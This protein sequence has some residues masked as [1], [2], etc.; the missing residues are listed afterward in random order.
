LSHSAIF[1]GSHGYS[2]FNESYVN[3]G[4]LLAE[5]CWASVSVVKVL[6]QNFSGI[7]YFRYWAS[8]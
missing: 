7:N 5:I 1:Y 2:D 4:M 6:K 3:P 8:Y